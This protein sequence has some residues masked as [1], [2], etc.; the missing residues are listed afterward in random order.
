MELESEDSDDDR[1]YQST[2]DEMIHLTSNGHCERL[3]LMSVLA[4][5]A[6]T[7]L[8]VAVCLRNLLGTSM[9]ESEFVKKCVNEITSKVENL[10]CK[11]G[12]SVYL[13]D[14]MGTVLLILVFSLLRI[15][16]S[17]STDS[18]RNCIKVFEKWSVI[19]IS[20]FT[21]VRMI[22]LGHMFDTDLGIDNTIQRIQKVVPF[23]TLS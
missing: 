1:H 20:S 5:Y 13:V 3:V 11:F 23:Q 2:N 14:E 10:E 22:S 17:V 21:G 18:I 6:H 16:E 15:G 9:V 8:A 12:E 19:E 4:P 7:Y